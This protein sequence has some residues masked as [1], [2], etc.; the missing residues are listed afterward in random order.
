MPLRTSKDNI[1]GWSKPAVYGS[2]AIMLLIVAAA[3]ISYFVA[4]NRSDK[5]TSPIPVVS[6]PSAHPVVLG[7]R[8]FSWSGVIQEVHTS[9][10]QVTIQIPIREGND[11]IQKTVT[12]RIGDD[13]P[14]IRWDVTSSSADSEGANRQEI[15]IGDLFTGQRVT[16]QSDTDISDQN[17][18]SALS[19]T[20]LI[21][22]VSN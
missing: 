17:V 13:I 21:S 2:I 11:T 22:P 9:D 4:S 14:V 5:E 3:S 18:I 16:F 10:R 7:A 19:F 1:Y 15:S 6:V 20:L 8:T 12:V